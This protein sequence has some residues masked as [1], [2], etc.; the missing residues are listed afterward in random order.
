MKADPRSELTE[1]QITL[2]KAKL[3]LGRANLI[4]RQSGRRRAL[5]HPLGDR[6]PADPGDLAQ[7]S[8]G[9]AVNTQLGEQALQQMRE[10]DAALLRIER[11]QYGVCEGTGEPIGFDRLSAKPWARYTA[12]Y[13]T[14]REAAEGPGVS[15]QI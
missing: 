4:D 12:A 8:L 15:H 13:E 2:L 9:D 1:Q 14:Q 11:G 5:E 3:E 7:Q 10:I 6:E